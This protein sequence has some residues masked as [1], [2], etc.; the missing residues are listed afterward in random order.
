MKAKGYLS[1]TVRAVLM[2]GIILL[3]GCAQPPTEKV[4]AL[5]NDLSLCET[6][7]AGTFAPADFEKVSQKMAELTGLM[8]QKKYRQATALADSLAAEVVALKTATEANGK[9]MAGKLVQS[10]NQELGMLK[11]LLSEENAKILGEEAAKK[12]MDQCAD[13][14]G[15]I[16]RMQSDFDNGSYRQVCDNSSLVEKIAASAQSLNT[17]LEQAKA[18]QEQ[19]KPARRR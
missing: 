8:D 5:Q 13:Y 1:G 14:E 6:M 10:A 4:T 19:K 16:A 11:V 12:C 15:M 17:E 9:E 3:A 7:G 18:L 2:G